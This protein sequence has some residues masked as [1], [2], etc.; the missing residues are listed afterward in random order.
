MSGVGDQKLDCDLD[1][2]S[3]SVG[4]IDRLVCFGGEIERFFKLL[5]L[6]H[7]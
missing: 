5:R 3:L 6:G 4:E 2:L 7:D 1:L